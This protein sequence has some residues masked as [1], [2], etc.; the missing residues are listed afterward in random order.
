MLCERQK[1]PCFEQNIRR[2]AMDLAETSLVLGVD[3]IEEETSERTRTYN[4][5]FENGRI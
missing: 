3:I 1:V 4:I 2:E 5:D